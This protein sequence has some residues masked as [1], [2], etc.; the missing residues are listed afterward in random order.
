MKRYLGVLSA[1][2]LLAGAGMAMAEE[3]KGT[4]QEVDQEARTI[5]M[6][7]GTTYTAAEG[8]LLEELQPGQE[9][10]V[11]FEEEDGKMVAD[12][13]RPAE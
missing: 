13:I 12:E 5:I 7:D 6:E 1:L 3:A 11:S 4:L 8:V 9:V 2:A 10:T